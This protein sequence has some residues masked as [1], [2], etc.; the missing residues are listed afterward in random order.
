MT[1][2][3]YVQFVLWIIAAVA[4]IQLVQRPIRKR[5]GH[6]W[7]RF[8]LLVIKF[9]IA[10]AIAYEM[11]ADASPLFWNWGYLFSGLYL[12]LMG[13]VFAD[14]LFLLF[15]VKD[16]SK[17]SKAHTAAA[18]IF[19]LLIT[20]YGCIDAGL[21]SAH[22]L[23][24]TSEKLTEEHKLIF[25]SDL[26]Y[27]SSQFDSAI[28][29]AFKEIEAEKPEAIL[30]GGDMTDEHTTKEEMQHLYERIGKMG[31]PVFFVY[32]NHD[33]QPRGSYV[34]GAKYTEQDLIDAITG[35]GIIIL[36]DDVISLSEDLTILGREDPSSADRSDPDDLP[37]LPDGS[38]VIAMEHNPYETEDIRR[39]NAD[40]QL[41]GHT[42]AGQLFPLRLLYTFAGLKVVGEYQEGNT[43][44]YVSPGMGQW[45]YPLR[46]ESF[47][48][49]EVITLRP[50]Q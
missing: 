23:V 39:Q 44:V 7:L 3:H 38:Y 50:Q 34:G 9:L 30:L 35:N 41:S 40:L 10:F 26:H 12:A 19:T 21:I 33:R 22:E 31:I 24:F 43:V 36:K 16:K 18:V 11:I 6:L 13:D 32:G 2:S 29:K 25:I 37:E 8:V 14:L 46:N 17:R 15:R 45:F 48:W 4:L 28:E 5:E 20:L 49:Y 1:V 47:C 42:H 27:G